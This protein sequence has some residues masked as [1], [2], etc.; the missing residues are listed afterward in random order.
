MKVS[1]P[2][3]PMPPALWSWLGNVQYERP[4]QFH[5]QD[6][7]GFT[8]LD[9]LPTLFIY[10]NMLKT[11]ALGKGNACMLL[12]TPSYEPCGFYKYL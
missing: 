12:L 7:P 1:P 4:W 11:T 6:V 3:L 8:S 5:N 9:V 2:T 10:Y